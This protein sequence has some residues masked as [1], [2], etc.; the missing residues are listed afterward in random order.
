MQEG[1][2]VMREHRRIARSLLASA[3]AL[4][5]LAAVYI[6]L[7]GKRAWQLIRPAVAVLLGATVVGSVYADEAIRRGPAAARR[8]LDALPTPR[9]SPARAASVLAVA[10][11]FAGT[12]NAP[13][14]VFAAKGD[15]AAV[16][17]FAEQQVGKPY[18]FGATG[19]ASFDCSGLVYRAFKATGNVDRIGSKRLGATAY[20]RWFAA[21]GLVSTTEAKVGDLIIWNGGGHMG[22]YMGD[23]LTLDASPKTGVSIRKWRESSALKFTTFLNVN[24]SGAGS[25]TQPPKSDPP[26]DKPAKPDKPAK[27]AAVNQQVEDVIAAARA[28]LG[29]PYSASGFGPNKFVGSG[30]VWRA[31]SDAD[32]LP[33]IGERR[34]TAAAYLAWFSKRGQV[35]KTAGQRGDLVVY[36]G[37]KHV[38]I[39]LGKKKVISAL[40]RGVT[41]HRLKLKNRKFTGFLHVDWSV[42]KVEPISNGLT[43]AVLNLRADAGT[44][45][46]R[47]S[48]LAR[49][50][51]FE[52]IGLAKVK[53][54]GLWLKITTQSGRSGWI[55]A[56]YAKA[57][58]NDAGLSWQKVSARHAEKTAK[59]IATAQPK[60]ALNL[61][62][63]AGTKGSKVIA[64]LSRSSRLDVFRV[65]KV[66]GQGSWLKVTTASGKDGWVSAAWAA[67]RGK[68]AGKSWQVIASN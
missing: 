38:G 46:K 15:K 44:T 35:S 29:Q 65:V 59:P 34:K 33:R 53:G 45:N 64:V 16:L 26:S 49:G 14:P 7:F 31:F 24:W 48:V 11:V 21:R 52:V 37:G 8:S 36:D 56:T 28:Y 63:A 51:K 4:P 20:M 13:A 54:D 5:I 1:R 41:V 18:L 60:A 40:P 30:L 23:H 47:I 39:Y 67:P 25:G 19:P 43:T 42:P 58:G 57:R 10:V 3:V 6:V 9:L 27:Q 62:D 32:Q 66:K 55:S 17:A 22:F 68:V 61:R 50:T 12:G 2:L